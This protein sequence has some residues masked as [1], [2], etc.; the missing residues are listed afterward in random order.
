MLPAL[1]PCLGSH[2]YEEKELLK[3]HYKIALAL[4]LMLKYCDINIE[5]FNR[6]IK[7]SINL[8]DFR[9]EHTSFVLYIFFL[10]SYSPL[11]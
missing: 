7:N 11:Q 3:S 4:K 10:N 2:P 9:K 5:N 6:L 1:I 8:A